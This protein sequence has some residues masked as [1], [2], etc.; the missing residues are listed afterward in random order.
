MNPE[1]TKIQDL[2]RKKM[3]QIRMES[4]GKP[5]GKPYGKLYGKPYGK[6]YGEPYGKIL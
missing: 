2:S 4:H 1:L 3:L 6:P 5:Y